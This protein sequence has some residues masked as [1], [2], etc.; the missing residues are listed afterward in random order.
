[1]TTNNIFVTTNAF[2]TS[3]HANGNV[4]SLCINVSIV[5][6]SATSL[7]LAQA[8]MVML[9]LFALAETTST[10]CMPMQV[11]LSV[12]LFITLSENTGEVMCLTI[13]ACLCASLMVMMFM[14]ETLQFSGVF[15]SSLVCT[16]S[17][18]PVTAL[19][20]LGNGART[21][22]YVLACLGLNCAAM[23]VMCG[24]VRAAMAAMAIAAVCAAM[25]LPHGNR[26]TTPRWAI[27]LFLCGAKVM[28]IIF[29]LVHDNADR[30]VMCGM[31]VYHACMDYVLQL[32]VSAMV[33]VWHNAPLVFMWCLGVVTM[34]VTFVCMVALAVCAVAYQRGNATA[35]LPRHRRPLSLPR[36][37]P[38]MLWQVSQNVAEPCN[39]RGRVPPRCPLH[40]AHHAP[41]HCPVC[42]DN[43]R[44]AALA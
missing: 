6:Q 27:C 25:A 31:F 33:F 1:M 30:V 13:S 9:C 43:R 28:S 17:C 8:S 15:A 5:S 14:S 21:I 37:T 24:P 18:N 2:Q 10:V 3:C 16:L 19:I 35:P 11:V 7:T 36:W 38:H 32:A 26:G 22:T 40:P 34:C 12:I 29:T 41:P 42:R 44:R 4:Y 23:V 20:S 39:R